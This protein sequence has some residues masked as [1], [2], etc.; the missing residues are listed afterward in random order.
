MVTVKMLINE[1]LYKKNLNSVWDNIKGAGGSTDSVELIAVS[2][3]FPVE[4][5]SSL[6]KLGQISFGENYAQELME[7][8]DSNLLS[9]VDLSWH[10]IGNIQSNKV[11]KLKSVVD[12]WH[13][14]DRVSIVDELSKH[15]PNA[16]IFIQVNTTQEDTKSGCEENELDLLLDHSYLKNLNVLGLMTMGPTDPYLDSRYSFEKLAQ[17]A[18]KHHLKYLSMGMSRDYIQ[19]VEFGATHLRIGSAIFGSRS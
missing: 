11:K 19:A 9:D 7:K 8:S 6:I 2:K 17:L 10:F 3:F 13:T 14:V 12:I 15:Q 18:Q 16:R 4:S 1:D 5:I